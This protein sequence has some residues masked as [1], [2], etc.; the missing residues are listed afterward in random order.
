MKTIDANGIAVNH[1]LVGPEGG[2][3]VMLSNSLMSDLEMWAPQIEALGARYRVLRYDTRGHG[4]TEAT[5]AP[6]SMDLLV[7]DARALLAALGTGRVHFVGLSLGGMV[8]Q[9]LAI[10][11][12]D[13]LRSVVLCDTSSHMPP[14]SLWDGRRRTARTEGI[15]ALVPATIER[16]FTAPFRETG[17]PE[18]ERVRRM[19]SATGVEG[20][21]GCCEAIKAMN[22]TAMLSAI[23]VP[24]LIIVG[25]DD[26]STPV[27][28]AEAIH[29]EIRGSELV[30]IEQAAHLSNIERP[31]AFNEALLGFLD[32][33]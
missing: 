1:D 27:A 4:G 11:H 5:P 20:Y 16:W 9:L 26:P 13:L 22:Q 8:G 19:I 30:V 21:V 14:E 23:T 10:K 31:E 18:I 2:P 17:D 12:P 7:E 25:A 15:A 28:A 24:T 32:R 6:Y 3:V 29:R 33:H